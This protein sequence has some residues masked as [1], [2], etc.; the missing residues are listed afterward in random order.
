[1]TIEADEV[2]RRPSYK[3]GAEAPLPELN[4]EQQKA[5][6]GILELS[7]S[8]QPNVSLLFGVTGSGK[9]AV[10]IR[11][12]EEMLRRGKSS[13]LLVPEIPTPQMLQTFLHFET[14]LPCFTVPLP[15]GSAM[16][17]GSV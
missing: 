4:E 10:Y 5:F 8:G 6:Q 9:T 2:F 7:S 3:M 13:I 17:S 1:M 11:L 16:T 12:I 15:L 14:T